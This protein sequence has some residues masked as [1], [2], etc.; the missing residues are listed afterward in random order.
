MPKLADSDNEAPE[1]FLKALFKNGCRVEKTPA[2][3][4]RSNVAEQAIQTYKHHF[5]LTMSGKLDDFPTH[6]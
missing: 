6:Q 2:D 5:I 1:V 4:D 3:I